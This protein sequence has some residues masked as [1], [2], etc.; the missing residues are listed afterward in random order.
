[1]RRCLPT[2]VL[3]LLCACVQ[4]ARAGFIS[5]VLGDN[6]KGF[7]ILNDVPGATTTAVDSSVNGFNGAYG[8]GVTPLGIAGPSWVPPSGLVANFTGGTI[9]FA[10]PLNLG[11]NGYTIEAWINPTLSSLMNTTRIVASGSGLNGYGFGTAAGAGL[12]F[13]SFAQHDYFTTGVT[14]LPNQWQYVGVVVDASNDAN[15]YVNGSF[16]ESVTGI[17]PTIPP[18]SNFTIGNQSPGVGH[19]DEIFKGGLAGISVYDTALTAA[20]IQAQFNAATSVV[21]EPASLVLAGLATFSVGLALWQR[22]RK[23]SSSVPR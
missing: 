16:V 19:T 17:L 2:M 18:T 21:P 4:P 14:L 10:N 15:F 13:T 9:S 20:Q 5:Q 6:P 3:G 7:W 11:A 23:A 8:P 22:R 12:V 1:M